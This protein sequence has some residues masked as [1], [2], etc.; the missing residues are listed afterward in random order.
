MT[1][2]ERPAPTR[3]ALCTG[4]EIVH[5][6]RKRR[7]QV[8]PLVVGSN[9]TGPRPFRRTAAAS[10]HGSSPRD[11]SFQMNAWYRRGWSLVHPVQHSFEALKP[12]AP[13]ESS[14][15]RMNG[16]ARAAAQK[17]PHERSG[18]LPHYAEVAGPASGPA[19]AVF[20]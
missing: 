11:D 2:V 7:G 17:C 3:M 20:T 8:N 1:G 15:A 16:R 12:V 18:G 5:S 14:S 9:P 6:R 4:E 19:A 13:Y 10:H